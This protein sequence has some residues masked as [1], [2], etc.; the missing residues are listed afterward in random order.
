MSICKDVHGELR[1]LLGKPCL[2]AGDS[3]FYHV[4][5]LEL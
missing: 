4:A 5:V 3:H 1:Q 2:G